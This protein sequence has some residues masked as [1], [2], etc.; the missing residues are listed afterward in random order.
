MWVKKFRE[1]FLLHSR[2]LGLFVLKI[3]ARKPMHGYQITERINK[4]LNIKVPRQLIYFILL[5]LEHAG[6]VSSKW[7]E[8]EEKK[9]RKVYKITKK[10]KEFM[11]NCIREL[12]EIVKQLKI[13]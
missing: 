12:E 3:L 4:I 1:R 2:I 5:R 13:I 9:P 8:S 10:G 6:L 7:I 11:E